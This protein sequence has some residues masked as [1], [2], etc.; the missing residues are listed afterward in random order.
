LPINT[1]DLQNSNVL[2]CPEQAETTMDK[3]V[4]IGEKRVVAVDERVLSREVVLE[5]HN[6][7]SYTQGGGGWQDRL[8]KKQRSPNQTGRETVHPTI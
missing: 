1:T 8:K 7:G 3:N 5:N 2:I 4:L 6:Q